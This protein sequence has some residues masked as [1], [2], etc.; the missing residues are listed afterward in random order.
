MDAIT[1]GDVASDIWQSW[2]TIP[3]S[4]CH[5]HVR[6]LQ[7]RI[8]KAAKNEDWRGLKRLQKLLV[9][10]TSGKAVA[11][12]RV[13]E[14]RGRR[15]PGVDRVV[16]STAREKWHAVRSLDSR[17]Y[18]PKPLRR[19]HIPKASGGK[20]PLG[21]PTMRDRAMQALY[22]L[23]LDP[24]AE[25]RADP[26]SYGFRLHRSTAD[27]LAQCANALSR[28]GA[29]EWVLEGDIKGCFD[30]IGHDWLMKNVPM[31]RRVLSGW[32]KSGYVEHNRLFAT[33]AGT[34]QG[35]I[36]SPVLANLTLDGLE[37]VLADAFPRRAKINFIRYADDFVVSGV[38][39]DLLA[40]KVKP[41]IADF[42]AER[43]LT[44]SDTKTVI[45]RV[46]DGF[47]FLG[48][49]VQ[50]RKRILYIGPSRR[51]TKALYAKVR[52]VLQKDRT[53]RQAD[54]IRQLNPILVGWANYH[55][56][57]MASRVFAVM[58][59]RIFWA[60]WRWAARRHPNKGAR[61]IRNRYFKVAG[62]RSWV[63]TDGRVTLT[64]LADHK[65]RR[66][67]KI[68]GEANPYDPTQE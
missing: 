5:Q 9:R 37:R 2:I 43:G 63:F 15:T 12:R 25:T 44:L 48:F 67:I 21:I 59:H 41:L 8:A 46:A 17:A 58:D 23:A 10:S 68:K 26:N 6:R 35:G 56:T 60:L 30:N 19:I 65:K 11:V 4:D 16:W 31:D 66:H 14:N 51:S 7:A 32:L 34:P 53:A 28:K 36:I 47:D 33:Q 62:N 18:K 39:R 61:W 1:N 55:R 52:E 57:Q 27:A 49:R 29:S 45:T 38:S 50:K 64:K 24:V 13:T 40:T 22:W 20:R 42:L 54:V 3:W